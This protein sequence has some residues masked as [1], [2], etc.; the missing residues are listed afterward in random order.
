MRYE[1]RKFR[2]FKFYYLKSHISRLKSFFNSDIRNE[3]SYFLQFKKLKFVY[4]HSS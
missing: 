1:T 2:M 4:D 3:K